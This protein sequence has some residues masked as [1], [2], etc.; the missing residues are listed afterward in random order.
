M[1]FLAAGTDVTDLKNESQTVAD[2]V[3][4]APLARSRSDCLPIGVAFI[5]W[6][7]EMQPALETLSEHVR[8]AVR[9]FAPRKN[10]NLIEENTT[11]EQWQNKDMAPDWYSYGCN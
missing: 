3:A 4:Q 11:Y 1:G 8:A 10:E 5:K 9:L 6:G 7:V 2:L